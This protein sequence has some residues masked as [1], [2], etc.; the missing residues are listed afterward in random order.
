VE[1]YEAAPGRKQ[2]F[3][4]RGGEH[5]DPMPEDYRFALE[6]FLQSLPRQQ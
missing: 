3:R 1:L 2:F 4:I 6:E 5:L